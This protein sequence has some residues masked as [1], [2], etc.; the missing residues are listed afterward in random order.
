MGWAGGRSVYEAG[1]RAVSLPM[2]R[3]RHLIEV[4]RRAA[5]RFLA[6]H[7]VPG[8]QAP[9]LCLLFEALA[10]CEVRAHGY[11][12]VSAG[13]QW[14]FRAASAPFPC[15]NTRIFHGRY[16]SPVKDEVLA[17]LAPRRPG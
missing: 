12:S 9:D 10:R 6:A 11:I 2:G 8:P 3:V 5:D 15:V 13:L 7:C 17:P 14:S 4:L 16:R 1:A